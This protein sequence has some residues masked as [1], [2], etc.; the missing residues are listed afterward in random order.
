MVFFICAQAIVVLGNCGTAGIVADQML[1]EG[2]SRWQNSS[3]LIGD[4]RRHGD[5][6]GA[7]D[8]VEHR[9]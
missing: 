8:P 7:L 3:K 6:C 4:E 5:R 9:I 1:S 2:K